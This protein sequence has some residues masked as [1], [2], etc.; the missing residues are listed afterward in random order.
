MARIAVDF[1]GVLF[2][3]VPWVLRAFRDKHDIDLN[4]EGFRYWEYYQYKAVEE[5]GLTVGEV[6]DLLRNLETDSVIHK[7][8]LRDP[9]AHGVMEHWSDAGHRVDIVTARQEFSKQVTL[10][11]L[12]RHRVPFDALHMGVRI[13]TGYDLLIDDSPHNVLMAAAAGGRALLMDHPYNRDV[14]CE[15]NPSRVHDWVQVEALA[16]AHLAGP[17]A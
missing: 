4:D 17:D 15:T 8:P 2:D 3:H 7:S 9:H 6:K 11:F 5:A 16:Q 13:K 1:D 12:N 10:E 14:P